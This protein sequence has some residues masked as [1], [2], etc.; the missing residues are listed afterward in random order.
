MNVKSNHLK[1]IIDKQF[2][3]ADL[4]LKYEDICDN[5]IPNW[6]QKFT[7]TAQQN[8]KWVKW[9][10]KYIKDKLKVTNDRAFIQTA[11]INV[12]YGLKIKDEKNKRKK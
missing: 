5:K 4:N 8:E 9:T 3:I 2:K 12:N 1:K 6:Y 11:W 10:Q 7:C